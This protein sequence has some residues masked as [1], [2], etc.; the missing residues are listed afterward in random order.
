MGPVD[1]PTQTE[2]RGRHPLHFQRGLGPIGAVWTPEIDDF[3][4]D[5]GTDR[6]NKP[7]LHLHTLFRRDLRQAIYRRVRPGSCRSASRQQ[8]AWQL[9]TPA[10][11]R[12]NEKCFWFFSAAAYGTAGTNA[13]PPPLPAGSARVRPTAAKTRRPLCK[14]MPDPIASPLEQFRARSGRRSTIA[15]L[16]QGPTNWQE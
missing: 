8:T 5:L 9:R 16:N 7:Y 6:A 14:I 15:G 1:L 2:R 12:P 3:Q 11:N 10:S 4:A 13:R